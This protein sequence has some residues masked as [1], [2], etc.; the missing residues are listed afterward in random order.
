MV[1]TVWRPSLS[2]WQARPRC[3]AEFTASWL[4]N[5]IPLLH[6]KN[7]RKTPPVI[8]VG[9]RFREAYYDPSYNDYGRND[10]LYVYG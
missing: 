7:V 1:V 5:R 10:R 8:V 3:G 9:M 4:V 6:Y 2:L